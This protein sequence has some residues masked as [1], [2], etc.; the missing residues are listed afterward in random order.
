MN[1]DNSFYQGELLCMCVS[2]SS[3]FLTFGG[4]CLL[5]IDISDGAV[6]QWALCVGTVSRLTNER[7]HFLGVSRQD[8]S[9]Q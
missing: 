8:N 5:E 4:V 6:N 3:I 9:G 1:F 7:K 2:S